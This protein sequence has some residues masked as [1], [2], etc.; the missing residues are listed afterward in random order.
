MLMRVG[1]GG[2][3]EHNSGSSLGRHGRRV[4]VERP[5]IKAPP[6]IRLQG[7]DKW[8]LS[9]TRDDAKSQCWITV[10]WSPDGWAAPSI[11]VECC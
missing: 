7:A 9:D 10:V 6:L 1:G 4:A 3:F 8:L 11:D 5:T 2:Q